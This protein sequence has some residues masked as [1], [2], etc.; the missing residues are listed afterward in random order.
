M[1][2]WNNQNIRIFFSWW[3]RTL[4]AA[5]PSS[6][7]GCFLPP[8]IRL[9]VSETGG[10]YEVVLEKD[11]KTLS[12]KKCPVGS[13]FDLAAALNS[14]GLSDGDLG[15]AVRI[16]R[17]PPELF[18]T[19]TLVLPKMRTKDIRDAIAWQLQKLS[20]FEF[21]NTIFAYEVNDTNPTSTTVSVVIGERQVTE[22]LEQKA[23][24]SIPIAEF[25]LATTKSDAC[26]GGK[27]NL[28]P[29]RY[30]KRIKQI[31]LGSAAAVVAILILSVANVH[32]HA[33]RLSTQADRLEGEAADR[34][35]RASQIQSDI[36]RT[37]QRVR[38][39]KWIGDQVLGDEGLSYTLLELTQLI[40]QT[41]HLIEL[42]YQRAEVRIIGFSAAASQLAALI[43]NHP[44]F[45]GVRFNA[46]VVR[47]PQSGLDRFDISFARAAKRANGDKNHAN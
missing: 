9:I 6:I 37:N 33:A 44:E 46:P 24:G 13:N 14:A 22:N 4:R 45:G 15:Q 40:P 2:M 23:L 41:S 20:P 47:Q 3:Y 21:E 11:G 38:A 7:R 42:R 43:E 39:A 28:W 35:A 30:R 12:Q 31:W 8:D 5:L 26:P 29:A 32:I 1:P 10:V 16:L 34:L 19:Q 25:D 18:V 27:L 36:T 17:L